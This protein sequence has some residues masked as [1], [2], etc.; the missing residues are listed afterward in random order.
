MR[1][2]YLFA[3]IAGVLPCFDITAAVVSS[4]DEGSLRAAIAQGGTVTFGCSG[5]I[6]LTQAISIRTNVALNGVGAVVTLSGDDRTRLFNVLP[7]VEFQLSSLTLT[8]G[9]A[10]FGGAISNGGGTVVLTAMT[11]VSNNAGPPRP[12]MV[13]GPG[14]GGAVYSR[15][16]AVSAT[17]CVFSSNAVFAANGFGEPTPARGG[18]ICID[19]GTL[20]LLRCDFTRNSVTGGTPASSGPGIPNFG[21]DALGGAIFN[22]GT[23]SVHRCTFSGNEASGGPGIAAMNPI[24]ASS[25]GSPGGRVHGGVIHNASALHVVDSAFIGNSAAGG[26]GGSGSVGTGAA[27]GGGNGG[28]V[29]GAVLWNGGV[30]SASGS[31][32]ASNSGEG[33]NGGVPGFSTGGLSPGTAGGAGGS[34]GGAFGGSIF[35]TNGAST[36]VTNCTLAA[37]SLSG[38]DGQSG[39]EG[40][41]CIAAGCTI[42]GAGGNGGNGGNAGGAGIYSAGGISVIVHCTFDRNSVAA[43]TNGSGGLGGMGRTGAG[44]RGANGIPG[45]VE[46]AAF[47]V[48]TGS[49]E[50]ANSIF[51]RSM[52]STNCSGRLVDLGVNISSDNS[53]CFTNLASMKDRDAAVAELA[54]NGGPTPTI[55]LLSTSPALN[56]GNNALA[57]RNDQRGVLRPQGEAC[58]VGAFEVGYLVMSNIGN[59]NAW[60]RY[61]APPGTVWRLEG[62]ANGGMWR[63]LG[64]ATADPRGYAHYGPVRLTNQVEA[65]RT[66][67]R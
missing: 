32:F 44:A 55:A 43:G 28:S 40:A 2:L 14:A 34:G 1:K 22:D 20:S 36:F 50:T 39:G 4:C 31:A 41:A 52:G 61:G 9:F 65:F 49:A 53:A 64:T 18:A 10:N 38:G 58:D 29:Q 12:F 60:L 21:T 5:T 7:G 24:G 6:T 13:V 67:S 54:D 37:N 62:Q 26:Q 3:L 66:R 57:P 25:P 8:R 51:S 33:A 11:V 27:G 46:G 35:T 56:A 15:T 42:G 16:G 48:V 63:D 19:G 17:D 30:L 47:S 23:A 59:T 45:Y